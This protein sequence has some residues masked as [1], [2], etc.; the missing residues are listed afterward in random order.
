[1][2][3]PANPSDD[4]TDTFNEEREAFPGKNVNQPLEEEASESEANDDHVGEQS[5][6]RGPA[7]KLFH[8]RFLAKAVAET[9]LFF[10][11]VDQKWTHIVNQLATRTANTGYPLSNITG[12]RCK[13]RFNHDIYSAGAS[14]NFCSMMSLYRHKLPG[15]TRIS[16]SSGR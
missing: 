9:K 13:A 3:P 14:S 15:S 11:E 8:E 5:A 6:G 1:M 4:L 7:W 10:K 2:A 16:Q 12:G